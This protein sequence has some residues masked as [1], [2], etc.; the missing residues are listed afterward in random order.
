[1]GGSRHAGSERA[2]RSVRSARDTQSGRCKFHS[3]RKASW[4]ADGRLAACGVLRGGR[5]LGRGPK[6]GASTCVSSASICL[7]NLNP[8]LMPSAYGKCQIVDPAVGSDE[9]AAANGGGFGP[10]ATALQPTPPQR[11]THAH[12]QDTVLQDHCLLQSQL[13]RNGQP[14]RQDQR[15]SLQQSFNNCSFPITSQPPLLP[16]YLRHGTKTAKTNAKKSWRAAAAPVPVLR[17]PPG[18][19]PPTP[20]LP[21]RRSTP[22]ARTSPLRGCPRWTLQL[23]GGGPAA[24]TPTAPRHAWPAR[25]GRSRVGQARVGWASTGCVGG[26]GT[27]EPCAGARGERHATAGRMLVGR[28]CACRARVGRACACRARVGHAR[29]GSCYRSSHV[30]GD[31]QGGGVWGVGNRREGSAR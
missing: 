15:S 7:F 11:Q 31:W 21:R 10:R 18:C 25:A 22:A 27:D 8:L 23:R 4:E 3:V 16:K 2:A 13:I 20:L 12:L 24:G 6:G 30:I 17:T 19:A 28:A 9:Q 29:A 26:T 5:P 1:M 14:L